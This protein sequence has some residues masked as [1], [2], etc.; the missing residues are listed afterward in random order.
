[1]ETKI[2]QFLRE[3][4]YLANVTPA[5][6]EWYRYSLKW[7]NSPSP[8]QADLKD[9]VMRMR[10]KGLKAR[11]CNSA[12]QAF[13]SYAHWVYVG[14]DSKCGSACRHPKIAQLKVP[15]LVLPTFTAQQIRLLIAWKPKSAAQQRLHLLTL[16]L[17]DVGC[18]IGEALSL[19][20]SEIDFENLLV[21]LDGKGRKQ[22]VVPFSFEL[23]KAMFRYCKEFTR[24][25]ESLLFAYRTETMLERRNVLRDVKRLCNRL[26]F[27]P[28]VNALQVKLKRK[29]FC[30]VLKLKLIP[31]NCTP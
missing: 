25:P 1:M 22:R 17:L 30:K 15:D 11:G 5:T 9:A 18:R 31:L 2:E 26:G 10:E 12:I 20:V 4:R 13:N 19:H 29:R 7:L 3:R 27:K 24:K 23:R 14:S 6:I 21:T 28:P 16:L 8:S